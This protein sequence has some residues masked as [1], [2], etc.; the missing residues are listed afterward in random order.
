MS[1]FAA[2]RTC[3]ALFVVTSLSAC[4]GDGAA[5]PTACDG[6]VTLSATGGTIPTV[7]WSPACLAG[8]LVVNPLPPSQG[9]GWHWAVT[10]D[11][12]LIA[13]GV[14]FGDAPEGTTEDHPAWPLEPDEPYTVLLFDAEGA[15]IGR[16][17]FSP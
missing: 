14:R 7:R 5:P 4:G 3:V 1:G 10:A 8:R 6:P 16:R 11:S 2:P 13:P 12:R 17:E 9:F 15:E